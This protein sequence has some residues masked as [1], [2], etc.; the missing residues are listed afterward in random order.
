MVFVAGPLQVGKTTLALDLP[1]ARSGYLNWDVAAD[2]ER[3][4]RREL[5]ATGFWVFDDSTSTGRGGT[6]SRVSTTRGEKVTRSW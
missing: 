4:L 1:G 2:R 3:I 6:F 5:P